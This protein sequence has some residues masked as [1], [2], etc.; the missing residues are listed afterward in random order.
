MDAPIR[1]VSAD[2]VIRA[3][4]AD[5]VIRAVSAVAGT[6]PG[7]GPGITLEGTLARAL[8]EIRS[9]HLD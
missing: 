4:S 5:P 8:E 2:P 3:V 7:T 1:A 6:G 9:A